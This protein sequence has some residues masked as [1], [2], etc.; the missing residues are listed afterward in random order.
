M[1]ALLSLV[2]G[3]TNVACFVIGAKVGQA[4]VKG[5]EIETPNLNPVEAH[6]KSKA[7]K[8]AERE[9]SRLDTIFENMENYDGTSLGQK[10]VPGR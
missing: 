5:K 1:E 6:R 2:M 8:E 9:Q 7:R 4:V 3:V 10:E